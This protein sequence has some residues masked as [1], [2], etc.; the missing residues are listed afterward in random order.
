MKSRLTSRFLPVLAAIAFVS[1]GH[2]QKAGDKPTAEEAAARAAAEKAAASGAQPGVIEEAKKAATDVL[3][4]ASGNKATNKTIGVT[5][6]STPNPDDPAT[7]GKDEIHKIAI[8]EVNYGGE[9]QTVMFE[10][11]EKD[12]PRTVANFEKNCAETAYNGLAIHRAID[13]YLVQ[14]G[15]PLTADE[16]ARDRWGTGGE[17]K[18]IPSEI[19]RPHKLGAVAMARRSDKVNPERKSNGYQFYFALGNMS[20]L[21]GSYTVFGQV[22]SGL[23]TLERISRVP[24][25]SNDSPLERI[26]VK[27]IKVVDQKGPLLVLRE[28]MTGKR[29]YTKPYGAKSGLEKLIERVW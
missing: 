10:L 6:T 25:D 26:E 19:K 8:M 24:A 29:R 5:K 7:W 11:F 21:N 3:K 15:D 17:D 20:A 18:L 12:A 27:S 14:T 13:S 9:T 16:S 1:T 23:E 4:K 22:I 2:A 28:S